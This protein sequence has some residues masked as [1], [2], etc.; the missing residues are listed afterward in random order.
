VHFVAG[1]A[2]GYAESLTAQMRQIAA[3]LPRGTTPRRLVHRAY[4]AYKALEDAGDVRVFST[5]DDAFAVLLDRRPWDADALRRSVNACQ[6]R[7]V[8]VRPVRDV[9]EA[10]A[11]LRSLP[12][13]N[14]QSVS[15]A[16][17]PARVPAFAEA[18]GAAGATAIRSLGR[19]AFPQLS[20]SWDGLLPLD[21]GYTRPA[22]HFT[23]IE[24]NHL[25]AELAET[26][27]RWEL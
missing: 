16:L 19:A 11:Y 17:E 25:E 8:I 10:P 9:D 22:G 26:A 13:A 12:P 18:A 5:Y 23:T 3:A 27:A 1:D 6:G 2:D 15:V 7:T 4:D 20:H 21:A 14:L 24:F